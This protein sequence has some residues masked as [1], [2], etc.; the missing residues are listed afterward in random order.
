MSADIVLYDAAAPAD[1][2][3][4][5]ILR[6]E[7]TINEPLVS[8]SWLDNG[9]AVAGVYTLVFTS[10][11]GI[12]VDITAEDPKNELV[13]T[14]ITV[15]ADGSTVN[16]DALNGVG[17]VVDEAVDTGWT[18][19][20]SVGA[21][22]ASDAGVTR[23]L[24]WGTVLAGAFGTAIKIAAK[25]VG[26]QDA[27]ESK[28]YSVPGYR[29]AG[30]NH[31]LLFEQVTNHSDVSRHALGVPDDLALTYA[32]YQTGTPN[33][34][35]VYV[36][37]TK[38]IEDAKL[39]GATLYEHGAGN[40]YVDGA[41]KFPGMGIILANNPGDP[42][43]WAHDLYVRGG[44]D[45]LEFAADVSGSPGSYSTGPLTL[46][47]VGQN[48]GVILASQLVYFWVRPNVGSSA[49][50]GDMRLMNLLTNV[51]SI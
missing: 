1:P 33:T 51:I 12:T 5:L 19:K 15:V 23:R 10:S 27:S 13:G 31:E 21:L 44:Y 36:D 45:W 42:T 18:C 47:E 22:M 28:V 17:L 24:N 35:D 29:L 3:S 25:N 43:S 8:V 39:D 14:G 30:S 16:K 32:N 37:G 40:G 38:A 7:N 41:D 26:A 2:D 20:V 48:A 50:P 4:Q 46:T 6:F 9:A 34:V 49:T 11:G